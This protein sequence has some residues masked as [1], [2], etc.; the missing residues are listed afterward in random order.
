MIIN[1]NCDFLLLAVMSN[2]VVFLLSLSLNIAFYFVCIVP[3]VTGM[4]IIVLGGLL[5]L[6]SDDLHNVSNTGTFLLLHFK[7]EQSC[8]EISF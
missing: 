3:D 5:V 4:C 2:K 6:R 1:N 7:G 8:G